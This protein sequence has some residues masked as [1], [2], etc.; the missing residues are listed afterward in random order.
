MAFIVKLAST[1]VNP[2][3]MKF[4]SN[5]L[6]YPIRPTTKF[7]IYSRIGD[8]CK[9]CTQYKRRLSILNN[10]YRLI[11][12][13]STAHTIL[14]YIWKSLFYI[15]TI[16]NSIW[17]SLFYIYTILNSIWNSLFYIYI[18]Y[19]IIYGNRHFIYLRYWIIYGIHYFIYI[20]IR[21]WIIYGNHCFMYIRCWIIYGN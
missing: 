7:G 1:V 17:N 10:P 14:K 9:Q 16:L 21:Y 18:R 20:Y 11:T 8:S 2:R 5:Q 4:C 6:S 12:K 19:W 15:F 13:Y 3:E